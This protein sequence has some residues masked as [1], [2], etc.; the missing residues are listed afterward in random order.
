LSKVVDLDSLRGQILFL[1]RS[2]D[3]SFTSNM[4]GQCGVPFFPMWFL[5]TPILVSKSFY[6][7]I[8]PPPMNEIEFVYCRLIMKFV[9]FSI[10]SNYQS[11]LFYPFLYTMSTFYTFIF[12]MSIL[13][14]MSISIHVYFHFHIFCHFLCNRICFVKIFQYVQIWGKL[15]S[16]CGPLYLSIPIPLMS[17]HGLLCLEAFFEDNFCKVDYTIK[18]VQL[19]LSFLFHIFI[20]HH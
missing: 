4:V 6:S 12:I 1:A 7:F 9:H 13:S 20:S 18:S 19:L 10:L 5:L 14:I 16:I 3:N 8:L 15:L 17:L 2:F 11:Y